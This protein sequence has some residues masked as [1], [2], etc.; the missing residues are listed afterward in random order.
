MRVF[1][2]ALP[3]YIADYSGKGAAM[4]GGRWNNKGMFVLYTSESLAVAAWEKA[5]NLD[6]SNFPPL[7][8]ATLQIPSDWKL[9]TPE[10]VSQ[11]IPDA[12]VASEKSIGKRWYEEGHYPILKVP[13]V[14]IQGSYNYII[15]STLPNIVDSIKEIH[16]EPF[17][18][19]S[20]FIEMIRK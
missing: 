7:M 18:F 16:L 4:H 20:R 10:E 9:T 2:I 13:S 3:K 8:V 12:D 14:A 1:R 5:V 19:D 6:I 15:N 17:N 11:S